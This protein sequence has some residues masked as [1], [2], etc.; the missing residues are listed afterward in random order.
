MLEYRPDEEDIPLFQEAVAFDQ[1]VGTQRNQPA[2]VTDSDTRVFEIPAFLQ[3]QST[4]ALGDSG[5]KKNFIKEEF[6]TTL[7]LPINRDFVC[8]I[9][10]GS[11]SR[12]STT[13]VV[14][15]PFRFKGEHKVYDLKFHLLPNCIH[16]V[17]LGKSFLKLT[18]TFTNLSNFYSRVKQRVI[19]GISQF[20]FLYLGAAGDMFDGCINGKQQLA[21]AD[22]GSKVLVMDED[23]AHSI[24]I[25]IQTGIEHETT[26]RFADKSTKKTSGMAYGVE[27]KF[28]RDGEFTAPY[29]LNFHVLK[30]APAKVILCDTFLC[31]N[32]AFS[33]Y[34]HYLVDSD[35][36]EDND[37][38]SYCFL[39]DVVRT[40]K[41]IHGEPP[42]AC[43][44]PCSYTNNP[45]SYRTSLHNCRL[46]VSGGA[47]PRRR[48]GSHCR[49][50]GRGTGRRT[51]H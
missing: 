38:D 43:Q 25:P 51:K 39:I 49:P 8:K 20:D 37:E 13:G 22:F 27:W 10:I 3:G 46:A 17:I 6:A 24:G 19:K 11:G 28:G 47:P 50:P 5:A 15:A 21:L 48:R 44:L 31:D 41:Q 14:T 34:G 1:W 9:T 16:D 35:E 42:I 7:G 29:R 30:N 26:L 2:Y 18:E 36:D 4:K 45:L 40:K 12:V 23:Y 33:R 32:E